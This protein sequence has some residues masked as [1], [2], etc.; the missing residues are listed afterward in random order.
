MRTRGVGRCV[1]LT[2]K[3]V[4]RDESF[5]LEVSWSTNPVSETVVGT[6]GEGECGVCIR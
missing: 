4:N 2:E 3:G 6:E 1:S 5:I